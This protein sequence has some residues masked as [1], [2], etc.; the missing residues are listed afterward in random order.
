MADAAVTQLLENLTRLLISFADLISG[1]EN[2]LRCL[3]NELVLLKDFLLDAATKA[4]KDEKYREMEREIKEFAHDAEYTIDACLVDLAAAKDYKNILRRRRRVD[5]VNPTPP[6]NLSQEV[7]SI[8]EDKLRPVF[9]KV[10]SMEFGN[11]MQIGNE[12][13]SSTEEQRAREQK[14]SSVRQDKI[15]G[16]ENEEHHIVN[17]LME[18]GEEVGIVTIVGMPS[19]GKTT[20]AWRVYHSREIQYAFPTRI[21]AH[22]SQELNPRTLLLNILQEFTTKDMSRESD[23]SLL[24][25][26]RTFLQEKKFLL[27]LDDVWT[28]ESWCVIRDALP[29]NNRRGKVLITSRN[30]GVARHANLNRPTHRLS[31]LNADEGWALLNLKVFGKLHEFPQELQQIGQHISQQCH[32]FPFLILLISRILV[33]LLSKSLTMSEVVREWKVLSENLSLYSGSGDIFSSILALCYDRL[34]DELRDCFLYLGVFPEDYEIPVWTLTQLW[35]AEGFIQSK[36]GQTL[37]ETAEEN[38]NDLIH[39]NLVMVDKLKADGKV[40]T[41]RISNVVRKFCIT[42]AEREEKLFKD[43]IKVNRDGGYGPHLQDH[44]RLCIHSDVLDFFHTQPYVPSVRSF[45]SFSKEELTLQTEDIPKIPAAFE[46]IRVLHIKSIRFRI[47]PLQLTQLIHL[48]YIV[49]TSDFKVLPEAVSGLKH[50]QTL[51]IQ[52]SSR[53]LVVKADIWKMFQLRHVKTN[54][55]IIFSRQPVDDEGKNLQ[56]LAN[57]PPENCTI[58]FFKQTP[59]LKKLGIRGR[60]STSKLESLG[61]LNF[62]E[63]LKLLNDVHTVSPSESQLRSLPQPDKFPPRLRILTLS[64]TYLQWDQMFILGNLENL[65]VLK[66][67]DKAFVGTSWTVVDGMFRLLRFLLIEYTDLVC[68]DFALRNA[69]QCFPSLE[70]LTLRNCE[71]LQTLPDDLANMRNLKEMDLY[72]TSPA[73]AQFAMKIHDKIKRQIQQ[74]NASQFRS[75]ISD[76]EF[77]LS[78]FPPYEG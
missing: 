23:H 70:L 3:I 8:R 20:L 61:K 25:A 10:L 54:A 30:A 4:K 21:W 40:K 75:Q 29:R 36:Q 14:V 7:R 50:T 12:S 73:A 69:N 13:G 2:E 37:E 24:M 38:L 46:L 59:Y 19:L 53:T 71:E 44:R 58:C 74:E 18:E 17:Y 11:N 27:V 48:K 65:E 6:V 68:W 33:D 39:K 66:L 41:C 16:L 64:A 52:T 77:K 67:K 72:R 63:N 1:A 22:V 26:V 15:I 43:L 57:I 45:L 28:V 49:L 42:K 78:I 31:P 32:G 51:I 34:R 55:S 47:F 5:L 35:I 56:T 76:R 60:L 62:L 9:S